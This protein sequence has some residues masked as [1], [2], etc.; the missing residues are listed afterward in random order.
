[1]IIIPA[2][3]FSQ[4][5]P[6][7]NFKNQLTALFQSL[8]KSKITSGL[9]ADYAV[10]LAEIAPFNGVP[11]DTNYVDASTWLKLYCSIYDAKINNRISLNTPETVSSQFKNATGTN[12]AVPLTVMHYEYDK[13]DDNALNKGWVTYTDTFCLL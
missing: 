13:L 11:S 6:K 7:V 5:D 9:L 1:M 12:N 10:E 2:I 3:A 4:S 8:D